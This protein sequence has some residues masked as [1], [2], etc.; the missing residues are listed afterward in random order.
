MVRLA[1]NG[2][3]AGTAGLGKRLEAIEVKLVLKGESAPGPTNNPY[4]FKQPTVSYASHIQTIGWQRF[5]ANGDMSGTTDLGKR[6]EA[7][8]IELKDLPY[9]GG[10]KYRTHVQT[11]GWQNWVNNGQASGTSGQGKR[12]R[13]YSNPIIR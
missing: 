5:V 12:F 13:G 3:Q 2:Q 9:L 4:V 10:A 1:E 6:L 8:K 11:Y 7:V